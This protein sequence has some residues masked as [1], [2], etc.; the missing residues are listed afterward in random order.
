MSALDASLR[1]TSDVQ[2]EDE[3][4]WQARVGDLIEFTRDDIRADLFGDE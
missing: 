3:R 2:R 1:A 4:L